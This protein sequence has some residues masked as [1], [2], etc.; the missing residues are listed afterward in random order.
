VG[1]CD[2][3]E[4][5][6]HSGKSCPP[7]PDEH[8]WYPDEHRWYPARIIEPLLLLAQIRTLHKAIACSLSVDMMLHLDQE[9]L[10]HRWS[11]RLDKEVGR[12]TAR[13]VLTSAERPDGFYHNICVTSLRAY[14]MHNHWLTRIIILYIAS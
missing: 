12:W 14:E 1:L 2:G 7:D 9:Y 13:Y 3:V 10:L 4:R 5:R 11:Q 8:R 6:T